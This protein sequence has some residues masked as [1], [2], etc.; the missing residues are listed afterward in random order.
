MFKEGGIMTD[1]IPDLEVV[2]KPPFEKREYIEFEKDKDY[3]FEMI[4]RTVRKKVCWKGIFDKYQHKLWDEL[5]PD[6]QAQFDVKDTSDLVIHEFSV[7]GETSTHQDFVYVETLHEGGNFYNL[8]EKLGRT[9]KAGKMS[10][11]LDIGDKFISQMIKPEGRKGFEFDLETVRPLDGVQHTLTEVTEEVKEKIFE[12]ISGAN[13]YPQAVEK[14]QK[15]DIS[16]LEPLLALH[17]QNK[18]TFPVK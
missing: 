12:I 2:F 4:N 14:I 7:E 5:P 9:P 6:I 10:D 18:I 13:D 1:A 11:M 8:I 16:L 17:K 3:I 15:E